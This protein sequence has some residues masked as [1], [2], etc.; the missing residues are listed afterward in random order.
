[1]DAALDFIVA[2]LIAS[3]LSPLLGALLIGTAAAGEA[4]AESKAPNR[5]GVGANVAAGWPTQ[6]LTAIRPPDLPGKF[7]LIW[8]ELTVNED[9]V[10]TLGTFLPANREP[11]IT[12]DGPD[13][14][15][16]REA[17]GSITV[18]Y[19]AN[20]R[21]LRSPA[22]TWSG[23]AHGSGAS[24]RVLFRRVGQ[25]NLGISARDRDGLTASASKDVQV[26]MI[27]LKPGQQPF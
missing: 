16:F 14:V 8:T 1:M 10:V 17:I 3:A 4:L 23:A 24:K 7:A 22:I 9:G 27:P 13:R 18:G 20:A 25:V 2:G 12:I 21:D 19:V 6:V 11:R 15:S 26:S 5:P